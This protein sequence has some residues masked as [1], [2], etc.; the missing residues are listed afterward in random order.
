[1]CAN[2]ALAYKIGMKIGEIGTYTENLKEKDHLED[3]SV[4]GTI[5]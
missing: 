5:I 3:P 4:N 1:L 2:K